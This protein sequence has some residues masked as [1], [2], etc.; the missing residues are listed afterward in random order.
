MSVL[1]EIKRAATGRYRPNNTI[2]SKVPIEQQ[3]GITGKRLLTGTDR[4]LNCANNG[5]KTKQEVNI[6]NIYQVAPALSNVDHTISN[7]VNT[8]LKD[9]GTIFDL[10]NT[11]KVDVYTMKLLRPTLN[12]CRKNIWNVTTV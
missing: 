12:H 9:I 2:Y 6:T 8:I 1:P 4:H 7:P 5:V 3:Y 11:M 10:N